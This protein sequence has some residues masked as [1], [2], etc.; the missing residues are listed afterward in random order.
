[1]TCTTSAARIEKGLSKLSGITKANVS[2]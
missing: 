1:M 2:V